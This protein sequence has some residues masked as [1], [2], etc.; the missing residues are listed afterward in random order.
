MTFNAAVQSFLD[1]R[2]LKRRT[3]ATLARYTSVLSAWGRWRDHQGLPSDIAALALPE[4]RQYLL[5]LLL[6][7]VPHSANPRRPADGRLGLSPNAV[8]STRNILRAF[9]RFLV[10][11]G[12][13]DRVWLEWLAPGRLPAPAVELQ[14]RAY[15][16]DAMVAALCAAAGTDEDGLRLRAVVRLI[17]ES[18][19]RLDEVCH[20]Q[21]GE[22]D[23][24]NGAARITGK[25]RKKRWVYWGELA[26][27][28]LDAYL[29]VRRGS[30][31]GPVFR[32][33]SVKNDGRALSTD[34]LR[35]QIKR[36]AVRAGVELPP[37]A[38][39]HAGR[40]AFA[41]LMIDGGAAISEVADLMGHGD[42]RTTM[43]YLH[44][45]PDKL[46]ATH[47]R[48]LRRRRSHDSDS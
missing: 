15:W 31:G 41:H 7:H 32:G 10:D 42:V 43:R 25:G 16:D 18:G 33:T 28:A 46:Q 9:V 1:D 11:Q 2:R 35:A 40:H 19:M 47:R 6:E 5:Y 17:H 34:A 29:A 24:V 26:A 8:R 45:R 3:P 38:P 13:L 37:G 27:S 39:V 36:L 4:L 44:E 21:D 12:V 23:L 48:A 14:D 20:L 22:C 30:P